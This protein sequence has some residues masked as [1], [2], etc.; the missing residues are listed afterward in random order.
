MIPD[1]TCRA[2]PLTVCTLST[3]LAVCS[4]GCVSQHRST[5]SLHSMSHS[6]SLSLF[7]LCLSGVLPTVARLCRLCCDSKGPFGLSQKYHISLV[8]L[9]PHQHAA[10]RR[11]SV[12]DLLVIECVRT[13]HALAPRDVSVRQR[14]TTRLSR[15]CLYLERREAQNAVEP[16][17]LPTYS[18]TART[19]AT[20]GRVAG[21]YI[22]PH[23]ALFPVE[24]PGNGHDWAVHTATQHKATPPALR[25]SSLEAS[26]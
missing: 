20:L 14:V 5:R 3:I 21:P 16:P 13:W 18:F 10:R 11:W 26:L 12:D 6:V 1:N 19:G 24:T 25:V 9:P 4:V 17:F 2:C 7:V 22:F 8:L 15:Q 23:C